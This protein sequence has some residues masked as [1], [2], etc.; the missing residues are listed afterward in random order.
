MKIY[1]KRTVQ[2]IKDM[3]EEKGPNDMQKDANKYEANV[4]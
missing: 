4:K 2:N 3:E 1:K